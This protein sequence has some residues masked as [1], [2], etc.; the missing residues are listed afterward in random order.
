MKE[1]WRNIK[2]YEGFYQ[3]SNLGRIKGLERDINV[4][5]YKRHLGEKILKARVV[6]GGYLSVILYSGNNKGR[7]LLIHRI[8]A[9]AFIKNPYNKT[10]VNH[11]DYDRANN[12]VTN[13]EWVTPKE[14]IDYSRK[15]ILSS[16]PKAIT[17]ERYISIRK[18]KKP[19]HLQITRGGAIY[20]RSFETLAEAIKERDEVLKERG[21]VI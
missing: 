3:V 12:S 2:G 4:G 16:R 5:G 1:D 10:C 20:Q 8:V 17:G 11:K 13:L 19:Y 7:N 21:L 9:E 15:H 14:N 18:R 6:A